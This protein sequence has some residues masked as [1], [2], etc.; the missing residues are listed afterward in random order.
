M[1]HP[2]VSQHIQSLFVCLHLHKHQLLLHSASPFF[3]SL[4][5]FIY[6]SSSY[7]PHSH[8]FWLSF[9]I[10]FCLFVCLRFADFDIY[11][12]SMLLTKK[13]HK[14]EQIHRSEWSDCKRK[15]LCICTNKSS[16]TTRRT[17]AKRDLLFI[18]FC[19]EN[20]KLF[21]FFA[22]HLFICGEWWCLVL[23]L[24]HLPPPSL[25]ALS[26]LFLSTSIILAICWAIS[27]DQV[28]V[29][30]LL[31]N[32]SIIHRLSLTYA[33]YIARTSTIYWLIAVFCGSGVIV[34]FSQGKKPDKITKQK[35]VLLLFVCG[36]EENAETETIIVM[37]SHRSETSSTRQKEIPN[38]QT[39]VSAKST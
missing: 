24:T 38:K 37:F 10:G 30:T 11:V 25:L 26:L 16:S 9:C 14:S 8:S 12:F 23:L 31:L 4:F 22:F 28:V 7:S 15:Q 6:L 32:G 36:H 18:D 34:L 1:W 27:R 17:N 5:L 21:S 19:C 13:R 29:S 35:N 33:M 39:N 2:W 3:S 20:E